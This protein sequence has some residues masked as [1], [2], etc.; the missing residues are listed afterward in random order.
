MNERPHNVL[1]ELVPRE[2]LV[3]A[4]VTNHKELHKG[5]RYQSPRAHQGRPLITPEPATQG[6]AAQQ[7]TTRALLS[8]PPSTLEHL[9]RVRKA[10]RSEATG[11]AAAVTDPSE[12][13]PSPGPGQGQQEPGGVV[14]EAL[15]QREAGQGEGHHP[16]GLP[17]VHLKRLPPTVPVTPRQTPVHNK[18]GLRGPCQPQAQS[19]PVPEW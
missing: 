2:G 10:Q 9:A 14:D 18:A 7:A 15:P 12:G 6:E 8:L 4:V 17:V 19:G 3:R 5:A 16:R 1:H 11:V 13:G